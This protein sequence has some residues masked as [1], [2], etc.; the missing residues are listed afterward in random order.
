MATRNTRSV[1]TDAQGNA[2]TATHLST[3]IV[4]KAGDYVVGA[5]Q[6]MQVNERREIKMMD[7]VGTDGHV[8]GAPVRSTDIS[9]SCDR[10]RFDKQ[11]IVGAFA[12]GYIHAHAQRIPFDIEIH[13]FFHDADQGNA[14]I[15]TLHQCWIQEISYSYNADNWMIT[16]SMSFVAKGI[17]SFLKNQNVVTGVANGQDGSIYLNQYEQEADRGLYRGAMDAAGVLNAFLT[18]PTS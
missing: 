17:S 1:F 12:R 7:E 6:K 11:R 4:I 5:V 8:D 3:N 14:I 2:R 13:D 10:I 16:D 15:T 18:D 9:G